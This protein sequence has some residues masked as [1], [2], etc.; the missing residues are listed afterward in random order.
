MK[1]SDIKPEVYD[2]AARVQAR[3]AARFAEIDA[4]AEY[5]TRRVME[6]FQNK[7]VSEACFAGTTGYGYDDLGR[8]VLDKIYAEIFGTEAALVRIN[9][10][11]GT[12]ALSAA[13]FS[14]VKPGDK[15]LALTG[16]PYDTLR[17]AIGVSGDCHGSLKFY[18]IEYGQVDMTAEGEPDYDAIAKAVSDEK[19]TAVMIQRSRG[20]EERKALTVEEI[21]RICSTVKAV[22]PDINIMVDNCYGE[23]TDVIEP[24]HV[25]ADIIAGSLIKNPGGGLAPTGGYIAG[26]QDLVEKAAMRLTTPGIGGECGST[27]GNN[28]LLFQ[29]LFLSPHTVAQALK[30]ACFCAGMMDEM[31]IATSPAWDEKRSDIIQMV[32]LGSAENMKRFCLGIQAGAPVDSYV[33]PEPWAMPGYDCPVIMAAGAF[34]QGSSIE[35]SADGPMREPYIAY[36]QGGLTYESGKFGI[37]MAVSAMLD[38]Q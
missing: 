15:I 33:T 18:G 23:F 32:K 7:R 29:G 13:M 6:A 28:R 36:M 14:L 30:T 31:G 8:E 25:G 20:Y 37:M 24:T 27:L 11:N 9:F 4:V 35:L 5:N 16:L 26:K 19:V 10:V 22:N 38:K 3:L 17:N 1:I 21:G 2:M 12:H 34:I